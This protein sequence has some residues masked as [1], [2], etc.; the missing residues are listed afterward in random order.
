MEFLKKQDKTPDQKEQIAGNEQAEETRSRL[1]Q[2]SGGHGLPDD[3]IFTNLMKAVSSYAIFMLDA[4]GR[5]ASWNKGAEC[6]NGYAAEEVIGKDTSLFYTEEAVR[7]GAPCIELEEA[8]RAGSFE[9]EGWRLRKDKSRYWANIITTTLKGRDGS[10][11]GYMKIV[12]DL[13][14][15]RQTH[16]D[17]EKREQHFRSLIENSLDLITL[18]DDEGAIF[19]QSNSIER[20][21]GFTAAEVRGKSLFD[22]VHPGDLSYVLDG[23]SRVLKDEGHCASLEARVRH[24]HGGWKVL[25]VRGSNL[26]KNPNIQGI[27]INAVDITERKNLEKE[28]LR[29]NETEQVRLGYD[30]HDGLTQHLVGVE[31]M[32]RVLEQK[33]RAKALDDEA[34]HA[35]RIADYLSQ[36]IVQTRDLARELYP[37][38]LGSDSFP[39]VLTALASDIQR[40][41]H[42]RC[43]VL[44]SEPIYIEDHE[45]ALN[46]YQ[47]VREAI[48]N[49]IKTGRASRIVIEVKSARDKISISIR[50]DGKAVD[51]GIRQNEAGLRNIIN[52]AR[53]INAS[54]DFE[55]NASGGMTVLCSF[56]N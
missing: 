40:N 45:A 3:K 21:L 13:T 9:T 16:S 42:I 20:F 54:L 43:E 8:A 26:V 30:L 34:K 11:R 6:I 28:L 25:E 49:A 1:A 46:A 53:M 52:R 47:I 32:V 5:I 38:G 31:F 14:G 23:F 22:F 17:L 33:L 56:P 24:K 48:K 55:G 51:A 10:L 50:D 4:S 35:T 44:C 15:R 18:A 7:N 41:S 39:E 36:A 19:F 27:M 37:M 2:S 29:F 12:C